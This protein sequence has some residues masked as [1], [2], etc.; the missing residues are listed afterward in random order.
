VNPAA[1]VVAAVDSAA[2]VAAAATVNG[3]EARAVYDG[4]L[5]VLKITG[6]KDAVVG[7]PFTVRWKI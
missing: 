3:K 1:A 7:A 2:L 5:G 6:L 4:E